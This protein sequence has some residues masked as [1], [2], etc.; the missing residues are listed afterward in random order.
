MVSFFVNLFFLL[1]ELIHSCLAAWIALHNWTHGC[2]YE[3]QMT[4]TSVGGEEEDEGRDVAD[5]GR[6][7]GGSRRGGGKRV[8]VGLGSEAAG[9]TAELRVCP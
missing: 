7:V 5:D 1:S 6:N 3:A 2:P 9:K 8:K 4:H